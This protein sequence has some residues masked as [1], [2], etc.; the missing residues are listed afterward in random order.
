MSFFEQFQNL[1]PAWLSA[2]DGGNVLASLSLLMDDMNARVKAGLVARFPS[3]A[4]DDQALGAIGRDRSITRGINEPAA[5]YAVRLRTAFDAHQTQ[6]NPFTLLQQIQAYLQQPCVVRTVDASG[7]WFSLDASGNPS[8]NLVSGVWTWDAV[9]SSFW[10]RFWVVIYPVGGTSPFAS[11]LTSADVA[12]ATAPWGLT[13]TLDQAAALRDIVR[14]WKP[15]NAICQWIIVS[16]DANY[17]GPSSIAGDL[18]TSSFANWGTNTS[19][20]GVPTRVPSRFSQGRYIS[21]VA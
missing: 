1:V 13:I 18:P 5:A 2:G 10:A 8:A 7:N 17:F 12:S 14:N 16:F 19:V 3:Y 21:G 20:S 15:A 4:P 9:D 11:T 6:G